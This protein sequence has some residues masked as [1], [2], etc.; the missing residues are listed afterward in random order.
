[1]TNIKTFDELINVYNEKCIN[2]FNIDIKK[3]NTLMLIY[4]G[5]RICL[6]GHAIDRL[7]KRFSFHFLDWIFGKINE[8]NNNINRYVE[9]GTSKIFLSKSDFGQNEFIVRVNSIRMIYERKKLLKDVLTIDLRRDKVYKENYSSSVFNVL[10][11]LYFDECVNK[12][13]VKRHK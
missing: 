10:K 1:M 9:T 4:E 11:T 12:I 2:Q 3:I 8:G 13:R 6:Y 5:H 7:I